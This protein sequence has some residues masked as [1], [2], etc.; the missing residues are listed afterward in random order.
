M[1]KSVAL[2][3]LA[4]VLCFFSGVI[5]SDEKPNVLDALFNPV[6]TV[7]VNKDGNL[8]GVGGGFYL[9]DNQNLLTEVN[10][11]VNMTVESLSTQGP[12]L[13]IPGQQQNLIDQYKKVDGRRVLAK[14]DIEFSANL[15]IEN[16][17]LQFNIDVSGLGAGTFRFDP[18]DENT[19]RFGTV[20]LLLGTADLQSTIVA[21]MVV[22]SDVGFSYME[23][24]ASYKSVSWGAS[25]KLQT[26]SLVERARALD[27][28]EE[29]ELLDWGR[30]VKSHLGVN[31]DIGIAWK[32]DDFTLSGLIK[33]ILPNEARGPLNSVYK[34]R[35]ELEVT[36]LHSGDRF[37]SSIQ[38][39]VNPKE[40]FGVLRDSQE[41]SLKTSYSLSHNIDF[42]LGYRYVIRGD[43]MNSYELD[44]KYS[45][46]NIYFKASGR[47]AQR[48]YG[49][50]LEAQMIF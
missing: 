7:G 24:I 13:L 40:G 26:I 28:Y 4:P 23:E 1:C 15:P 9:D 3:C 16:N 22:K 2:L 39:D 11:A 37:E 50:G 6:N 42:G 10:K 32:N 17:S 18:E 43:F 36:A 44:I 5:H 27:E 48:A 34:L 31:G 38:W 12:L 45:Y 47:V 35:P 20:G 46:Q 25:L 41:L 14:A 30:D 29:S 49:F 19:I 21:S 8:V 33:N